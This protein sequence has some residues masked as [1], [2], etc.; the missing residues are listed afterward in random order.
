VVHQDRRR[1]QQQIIF[2]FAELVLME[3]FKEQ[4]VLIVFII[5]MRDTT[6]F[7]M[8]KAFKNVIVTEMIVN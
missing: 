4:F 1:Q 3:T 8:A 7:I 6:I 5:V 2:I